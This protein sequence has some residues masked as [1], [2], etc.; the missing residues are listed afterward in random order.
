[1]RQA[2]D[3]PAAGAADV[4]VTDGAADL[5]AAGEL[6]AALDLID[7]GLGR[8]AKVDASTLPDGCVTGAVRRLGALDGR[9]D[10]IQARF[11]AAAEAAGLPERTGASSTT[12]WLAQQTGRSG[13]QA[14]RTS[15][16]AKATET[17]PEL[18]D[19]VAEGRVGPDHANTIATGLDR[20]ELEPEDVGELLPAAQRQTPSMFG[21]QARQL[22]GRRRQEK[23]RN[24]ELIAR[25]ERHHR[26]WRTPNGSLRYEG[27]LPPAEGDLLEKAIAGFYQPDSKEV[28]DDQRRTH[29]QRSADAMA[30]LL[31]AALRGGEAGDLGGVRP[32]IS[33]V[34]PLEAMAALAD[35]EQAGVTAVSDT[36]TV[37]SAAAFTKLACDA[38]I[39]RVVIGADN[40]PLDVGRAT[41]NWPSAI[42]AAIAAVDGGCRGPGCDLPPH[43]SIIHHIRWWERGGPTSLDN[44]AMLCGRH[45]D[46]IHDD[47]WTLEMDPATRRCDWTAPDGTTLQTHPSGPA[48]AGADRDRALPA[49]DAAEAPNAPGGSSADPAATR[50][51]PH[52]DGP[53]ERAPPIPPAASDTEPLR[54][55]L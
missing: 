1:M 6:E 29:D 8:L 38:A 28:P 5:G 36:G 14:A 22:A 37:L 33:L 24:Q 19:A 18:T 31:E 43:R 4:A 3:R 34:V 51:T 9:I 10:G 12:S 7:Q 49:P 13:G 45:H 40:R 39:R 47:G 16:L 42:R 20:G 21:R 32:H 27:L 25:D 48:A 23:L 2:D 41:R 55:D 11:V 35:A 54:L 44:G 17:A 46:F 30:G 15:R 53:G 50:P 26:Q 52:R